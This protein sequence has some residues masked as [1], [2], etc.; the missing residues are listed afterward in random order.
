[1]KDNI[2]FTLED[3]Q[4]YDR[5]NKKIV[6]LLPELLEENKE[7]AKNYIDDLTFRTLAPSKRK[8]LLFRVIETLTVGKDTYA[9]DLSTLQIHIVTHWEQ[10]NLKQ[11]FSKKLIN[12]KGGE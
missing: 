2:K 10:D 9:L 4:N 6:L 1:M 11:A 12:P 8:L 7:K 3:G 5:Q